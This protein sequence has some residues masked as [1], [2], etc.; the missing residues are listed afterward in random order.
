[1]ISIVYA[2]RKAQGS[3]EGLELDGTHQL[4]VYADDVIS[5]GESIVYI[6]INTETP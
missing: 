4:L 6:Q 3:Q 5:L 2:F 1:V